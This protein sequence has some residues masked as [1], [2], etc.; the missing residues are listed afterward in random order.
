MVRRDIT[1]APIGSA[2][3]DAA[4]RRAAASATYRSERARLEPYEAIARQIIALRAQ[5]GL[6]QEELAERIGTSHSQISRIENGQHR[7]SVE[8]LRR[9][10]EGFDVSLVIT[11]EPRAA[12]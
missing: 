6:S 2:A 10:A 1:S 8:T 3:T 5:H 7:T 11:F 4:R 9:I 12:A